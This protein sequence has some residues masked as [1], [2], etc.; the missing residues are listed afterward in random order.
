MLVYF[1]VPLYQEMFVKKY[2]SSVIWIQ[3]GGD[4]PL[5]FKN[6]HKINHTFDQQGNC[7]VL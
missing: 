2:I 3:L 1:F 4:G 6:S 7:F 5:F